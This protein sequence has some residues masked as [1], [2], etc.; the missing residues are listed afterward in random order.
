YWLLAAD[1]FE[2]TAIEQRLETLAAIESEILA[3]LHPE[4]RI[5]S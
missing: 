4:P 3:N 1:Y 2:R 5:H